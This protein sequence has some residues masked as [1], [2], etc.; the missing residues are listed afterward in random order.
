METSSISRLEEP[1]TSITLTV[2]LASSVASAATPPEADERAAPALVA[3]P[4]PS[5]GERADLSAHL[6]GMLAGIGLGAGVAASLGAPPRAA[7][8]V[9]LGGAALATVALAWRVAL[10]A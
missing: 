10:G 8:Q 9:L 2:P 5:T 7:T 4:P 6:L 1:R 3:A